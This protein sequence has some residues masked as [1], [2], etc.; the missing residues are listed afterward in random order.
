MKRVLRA[1][2]AG[3]RVYAA[4]AELPDNHPAVKAAPSL[5]EHVPGQ[6]KRS[7]PKTKTKADVP[8]AEGDG[9]EEKGTGDADDTA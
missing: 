7:R 4:G 2:A 3:A 1:F 5:F 8:T 9:Q 6:P